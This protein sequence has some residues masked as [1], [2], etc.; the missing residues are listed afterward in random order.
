MKLDEKRRK[1]LRTL[2]HDLRP[3]VMV[4]GQ[5]LKDSVRQ[6]LEQA[7]AHHELIKVKVSVGDRK[8]RDALLQEIAASTGA[9]LIQRVG[10]M[11]L[12]FRRNPEKPV[13][14]FP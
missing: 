10:N 3:V 11:G 4:A 1:H 8:V 2:G 6:E 14:Q 5:G 12:F 9:E 7:L 13:V